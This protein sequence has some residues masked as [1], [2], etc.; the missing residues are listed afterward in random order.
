MIAPAYTRNLRAMITVVLSVLALKCSAFTASA[1]DDTI[2]PDTAV[3]AHYPP[4]MVE[5]L[6]LIHI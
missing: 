5:G 3:A 6:S 4:L 1:L 2:G